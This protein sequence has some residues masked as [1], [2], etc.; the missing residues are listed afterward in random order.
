MQRLAERIQARSSIPA[1]LPLTT[2]AGN[3]RRGI[4]KKY[5]AEK[6]YGFIAADGVDYF[7]H[8]SGARR[9]EWDEEQNNL[10]L[11]MYELQF[12]MIGDKKV[13]SPVMTLPSNG[14]RVLFD[15]K[16]PDEE[17]RIKVRHWIY[18]Q[19]AVAVGQEA[20]NA[21]NKTNDE[22]VKLITYR[23]TRIRET[24][25]PEYADNVAKQFVRQ[26]N[27]SRMHV[28]CG[29]NLDVMRTEYKQQCDHAFVTGMRIHWECEKLVEGVWVTCEL[30]V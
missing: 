4:V 28:F 14:I 23:L 1:P 9:L 29:N 11:Q 15:T 27:H 19:Q 21:T 10:S 12:K 7:F 17:G 2:E 8:I 3:M 18:E 20:M 22:F 6:G 30:P 16:E 25:G 5:N 26:V 13:K 24:L